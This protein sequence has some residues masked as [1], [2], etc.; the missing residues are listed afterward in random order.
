M[1]LLT[2]LKAYYPMQGNS[3]DATA[4]DADGTDTSMTYGDSYGKWGQGGLFDGA[5]SHI[6]VTKTFT[7]PAFA[8]ATRRDL[9]RVCLYLVN[10]WYENTSVT[11]ALDTWYMYTMTAEAGQ[12]HTYLYVNGVQVSDFAKDFGVSRSFNIWGKSTRETTTDRDRL[13]NRDSDIEFA[14]GSNSTVQHWKGNLDELGIWTRALTTTE[15]A[16]LY[17]GGAGLPYPLTPFGASFLLR[18]I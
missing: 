11:Q 1:S 4:Y 9:S 18:M 15:V 7:L 5:S 10:G 14:I 2:D 6:F 13:M 16:Q 17:N 8:F 12:S 3:N